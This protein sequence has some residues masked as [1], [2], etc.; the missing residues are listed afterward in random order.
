M[1]TSA[2]PFNV[3]AGKRLSVTYAVV[4]ARFRKPAA[5]FPRFAPVRNHLHFRI[6]PEMTIGQRLTRELRRLV[7]GMIR[8]R[9]RG[10]TS[11]VMLSHT[12]Q[13]H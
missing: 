10:K 11:A 13:Q 6:S 9:R 1:T 5:V 2:V 8:P 7:A 4:P 3:R 12:W